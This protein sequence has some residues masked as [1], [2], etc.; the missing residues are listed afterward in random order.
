M[1]RTTDTLPHLEYGLGEDRLGGAKMTFLDTMVV[2]KV[3]DSVKDVYKVQLS[4]N[5]FAYLPKKHFKADSLLKAQP[6]YLTNT[7]KVY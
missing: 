1:G 7:W 5:H 6:F 3:V 4:K 2:I